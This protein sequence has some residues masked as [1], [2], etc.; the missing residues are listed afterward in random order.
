MRRVKNGEIN[1]GAIVNGALALNIA[2]HAQ[3]INIVR[4]RTHSGLNVQ[5]FCLST[6]SSFPVLLNT[7]SRKTLG[8]SSSSVSFSSA[9]SF[10]SRRHGDA[11]KLLRTKGRQAQT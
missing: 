3:A 7:F 5:V 11:P 2:G 4:A 6:L 8:Q 10:C 1:K 9:S